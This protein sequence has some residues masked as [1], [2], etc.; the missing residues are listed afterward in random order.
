MAVPFRWNVARREQLGRLVDGPPASVYDAFME[1]LREASARVV[2]MAG[3][4][5]LAFVG[6]SPESLFDYLSGVVAETSWE[7]RLLL[8][9]VSLFSI[10]GIL[11]YLVG[12]NL[13]YDGVDGGWFGSFAIWSP[14]DTAI[15]S[16]DCHAS[17]S[18]TVNRPPWLP[19]AVSDAPNIPITAE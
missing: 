3:G 6:R 5:R 19:S 11:Y 7:P 2:A 16:G 14:D 15:Q 1:D 10:A 18:G 17:P 4:S 9:N 12:Y 8:A 13:M